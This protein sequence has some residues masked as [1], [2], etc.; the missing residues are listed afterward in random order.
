MIDPRALTFEEWAER[1][2]SL[3][4]PFGPVP[5][6]PVED[7]WRIW[8]GL[9]VNTPRLAALGLPDPNLFGEWRVWAFLFNQVAILLIGP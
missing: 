6:D 5:V 8:A 1:T 4:A 3:V 9:I 7:R 2:A